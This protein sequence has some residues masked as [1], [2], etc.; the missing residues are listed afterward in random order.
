[1]T[2]AEGRRCFAR[3]QDVTP[4]VGAALLF[5]PP[6]ET[7]KVLRDCVTAGV[8]R[9][10][11]HRGAGKGAGDDRSRS[12]CAEHGIELVQDLCPFMALPDAGFPHRLHAFFRRRL[13]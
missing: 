2:E 1:M 4:S 8:N 10:W 13:A 11:V 3:L 12:F 6:Q 7:E 5:T 9:V